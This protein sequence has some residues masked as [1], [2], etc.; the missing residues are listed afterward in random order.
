[1]STPASFD[2]SSSLAMSTF[3]PHMA[4]SVSKD[5]KLAASRALTTA[6]VGG[7]EI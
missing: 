1:V 6:Q 7:P 2:L 3:S 4:R 5:L